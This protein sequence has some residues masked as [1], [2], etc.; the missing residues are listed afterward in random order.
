MDNSLKPVFRVLTVAAGILIFMCVSPQAKAQI[1]DGGGTVSG[2]VQDVTGKPIPGA[3][4]AVRNES[5]G[6]AK[7]ISSG[8]DGRFSVAGRRLSRHTPR[9]QRA[10]DCASG[11]HIR[12]AGCGR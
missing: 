11:R 2:T 7:P 4:L 9:L 8:P 1:A 10:A 3:F 12:G 6:A 5:T